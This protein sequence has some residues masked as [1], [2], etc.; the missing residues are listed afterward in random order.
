MGSMGPSGKCNDVDN[1]HSVAW[2]FNGDYST[3]GAKPSMTSLVYSG[4]V[5]SAWGNVGPTG[6]TA[7]VSS[8]T[9]K[10]ARITMEGRVKG[11]CSLGDCHGDIHMTVVAD[12]PTQA[13]LGGAIGDS[14]RFFERR[15][16]R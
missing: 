12:V 6:K 1:T 3:L 13:A 15:R 16:T 4:G 11:A 7:S 9:G 2:S 8:I 10:I 14:K 5:G